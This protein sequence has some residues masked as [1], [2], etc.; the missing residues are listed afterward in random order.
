M[1]YCRIFIPAYPLHLSCTMKLFK[2]LDQQETAGFRRWAR[3]NYEPFTPISGLWHPIIQDECR[4][5]NEE[6][7]VTCE[8]LSRSEQEE[9]RRSVYMFGGEYYDA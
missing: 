4:V 9:L 8:E 1:N 2:D 7:D 3:D 5:I 6:A